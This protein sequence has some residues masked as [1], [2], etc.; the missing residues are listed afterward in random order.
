MTVKSKNSPLT[1]IH[2]SE[3]G[4]AALH[5]FQLPVVFHFT[6]STAIFFVKYLAKL[7]CSGLLL[8]TFIKD[9]KSVNSNKE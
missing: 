6:L 7:A 9:K 5:L 1:L 2:K 8:S 3:G 4:C